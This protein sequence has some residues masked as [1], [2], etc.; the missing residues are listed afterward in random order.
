M[1]LTA[2]CLFFTFLM[3]SCTS[4][5]K[6]VM[7]VAKGSALIDTDTKTITLKD[8]GGSEEKTADFNQA[9][10]LSLKLKKEDGETVINV[11]ENGLYV[12]NGKN[13]TIIGSYQ[14]YGEVPKEE[15]TVSQTELKKG[16]DSLVALTQ[17]KNIS[18]ANRNFYILPYQAAKITNNIDAFIVAPYHR[19]TSIEK[20]TGKEPEVYRFWSIKEIRETIIKLT[21]MTKAT[22]PPPPVK[23]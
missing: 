8:G 23:K 14:K 22:P 5:I 21:G 19:M 9:G 10:V 18:A 6:R 1:K 4:N 17:N 2:Y 3:T 13:D 15:K 20:E 11:A 16:I 12:L 7:I